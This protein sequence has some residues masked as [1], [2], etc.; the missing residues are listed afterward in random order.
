VLDQAPDRLDR[1]EG[2]IPRENQDGPLAALGPSLLDGVSTAQALL[3]DD[4]ANVRAGDRYH[5]FGVRAYDQDDPIGE[6]SRGPERERDE[7]TA[8]QRMK[9]LGLPRAHALAF[10]RGENDSGHLIHCVKIIL[11][12][13]LDSQSGFPPKSE[14]PGP[15]P[16]CR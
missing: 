16:S 5:L 15:Y 9:N 6:R 8:A 7:R 10:A 2:H 1:Q 4:R 14:S 3:L 12:R 11:P 13:T